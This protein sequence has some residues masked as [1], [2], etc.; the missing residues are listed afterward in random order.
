[1]NTEVAEL[2][3]ALS[4]ALPLLRRAAT[5]LI[6][7]EAVR[8]YGAYDLSA[9]DAGDAALVGDLLNTIREA[10]RLAGRPDDGGPAWLDNIIDG[11]TP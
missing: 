9:L 6:S 1:M 3:A 5:V 10:E 4:V 11:N 8:R 7:Y 2:R